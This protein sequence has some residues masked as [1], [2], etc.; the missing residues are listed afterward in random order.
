ML[1]SYGMLHARSV[2]CPVR[3]PVSVSPA[4]WYPVSM[5]ALWLSLHYWISAVSVLPTRY[6]GANKLY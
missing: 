6:A 1:E 4:S 3:S 2:C 5:V